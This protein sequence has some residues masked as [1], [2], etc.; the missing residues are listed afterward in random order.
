MTDDTVRMLALGQVLTVLVVVGLSY[1]YKLSFI[2]VVPFTFLAFI[3]YYIFTKTNKDKKQIFIFIGI[4]TII[5]SFTLQVG[6]FYA[7]EPM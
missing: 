5:I 7:I 3:F 2:S 4:E 1:D 6:S